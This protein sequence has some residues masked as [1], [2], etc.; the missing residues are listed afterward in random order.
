[1]DAERAQRPLRLIADTVTISHRLG[2][3]IWLRGGW[4]MDLFLDHVTRDHGDI[5]RDA[6]IDDA[7][8]IAPDLRADGY[9][10]ITGRPPDQQL[11]LVKDGLEASLAWPIA[12]R[13]ARS[14]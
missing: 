2:V 14:Q 11:D 8:A 5:D 1:V 10:V 12:A 3:Q 9:L 6:W 4:A 13:T 7:P